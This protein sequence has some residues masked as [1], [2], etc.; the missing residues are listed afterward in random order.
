VSPG[1]PKFSVVVPSFNQGKYIE[2]TIRSVLDQDYPEK[3]LIVIDGGSTDNTL[4]VIRKYEGRIACWVS[5]KDRGQAHAVNKGFAAATGDI[6]GW[7]NSDDVYLPGAFRRAAEE[8]SNHPEAEIVYGHLKFLEESGKGIDEMRLV[9][10]HPFNMKYDGSLIKNQSA[11]WRRGVVERLGG[12]DETL[13]FCM[14][15][16]FFLRVV[17]SGARVRLVPRSFG[18]FRR[19]AGSKTGTIPAVWRKELSAVQARY[20]ATTSVPARV[21]AKMACLVYRGGCYARQGDWGYLAVRAV[22]RM[23]GRAGGP[24]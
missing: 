6:F 17:C 5:E 7:Q 3:E 18:A 20:G 24:L 10:A 1:P 19:H 9:P 13:S 14:D 15:Y 23:T 4:D 16:E 21:F 2:E 12:M 8:W 11:F 22:R